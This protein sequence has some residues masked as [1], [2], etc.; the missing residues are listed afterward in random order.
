MY[1][2]E[3]LRLLN[4][5]AHLRFLEVVNRK[6][7]PYAPVDRRTR[8]VTPPPVFPL[9]TLA[10]KLIGGPPSLAYFIELLE[11]GE[12]ATLFREMVREYLPELE[13]NIYAEDLDCR[14]SMFCRLFS[15]KFFPLNEDA[16][17]EDFTISD[18]LNTIPLQPMGFSYES[19]HSFTDFRDGYILALSLLESPW[20]EDPLGMDLGEEEDGESGGRI[21]ILERVGELVGEG[22]A[23]LI[24]AGGW[25]A[26]DLHALVNDTEFEALGN[27]ADWVF[28]NTGLY[29]L[30]VQGASLEMGEQI[31]WSPEE[32]EAMT[33]DWHQSCE[34]LDNIDQLAVLL[35]N[36]MEKT[37]RK[38]LILLLDG[39]DA[40]YVPK[41]QLALPLG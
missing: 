25:S 9:S 4:E 34:I 31:E 12:T 16:Y 40:F 41:E 39:Q 17:S 21:P 28:S 14:A 26:V 8:V 30:D 35:E 7:L 15:E 18:L 36:D 22:L 38:L 24:K 33:N 29:H 11:M 1:D 23:R 10:R 37:F 6:N 27:F 19:Y 13:V 3:V 32:V 20:D 5:Q 2:P